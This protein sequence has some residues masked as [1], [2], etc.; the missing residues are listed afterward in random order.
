MLGEFLRTPCPAWDFV[1]HDCSRWL[2]RYLVQR[3]HR[4]PMA[5]I[6]ISY[7][8]EREAQLVIGRGGGLL[9]LWTKGLEAIGLAEVEGPRQGD[10][11]IL[12]IPTDD[13]SDQTCGI[14]TGQRWASVHRT[15]TMFGVGD[16][17]LIWRV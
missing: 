2:D 12:S 11:A 8:S 5:A 13:G 9:A 4:S 10:V 7:S 14:W 6:D 3:G 16:P 17:L 15:G 1:N